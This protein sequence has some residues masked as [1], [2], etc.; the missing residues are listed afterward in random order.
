MLP[1]QEVIASALGVA[2]RLLRLEG[3]AGT[4]APG[5]GA[6]LLLLDADPLADLAVLADP[7]R[8][9]VIM[10]AGRFVRNRL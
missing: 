8:M 6:D 10:Q 2:A 3:Q 7:A 5:A 9:P 4:L 1:A